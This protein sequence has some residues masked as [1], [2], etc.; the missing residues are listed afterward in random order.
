VALRLPPE[1]LVVAQL[2][3]EERHLRSP[4]NPVVRFPAVRGIELLLG[5][6]VTHVEIVKGRR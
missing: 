6:S 1:R 4:W 3:T 2:S 5:E